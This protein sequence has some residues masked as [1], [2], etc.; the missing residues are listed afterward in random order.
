MGVQ[1]PAFIC[2]TDGGNYL[3]CPGYFG[4]IEMAR[5]VFYIQYLNTILKI[6]RVV[7]YKCSKL[8]ISKSKYIDIL[9]GLSNES[10]WNK[11]FALASKI[12]RCGDD[13]DTGCG[14][15]Q[16]KSIKKEGLATLIASWENLNGET[17]ENVTLHLNCEMVLKILSR[18]SDE[19]TEF[20][21]FS[22]SFS[23]PEWMICQVFAVPPPCV[24]PSVK[25]DAQQRLSLIHI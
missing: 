14:C 11:V 13:C 24:R 19:D 2:P 22:S 1:D 18:I 17:K 6:L 8:L 10:R 15:K 12:T 3:T 7:C 5:P 9:D 23:R 25:H 21:G 16:P 20:M 4:H